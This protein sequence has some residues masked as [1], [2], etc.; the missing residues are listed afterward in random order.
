MT[1]LKST[2]FAHKPVNVKIMRN[3]VMVNAAPY[4]QKHTMLELANCLIYLETLL[5]YVIVFCC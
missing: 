1:E 3:K 2:Y 4:D 5:E